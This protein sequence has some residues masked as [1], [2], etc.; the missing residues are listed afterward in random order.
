MKQGD[1]IECIESFEPLPFHVTKRLLPKKGDV[2]T[3]DGVGERRDG[4]TYILIKEESGVAINGER[5]CYSILKFREIQFP[6][7]LELEIKECLT[8]ELQE[9]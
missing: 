7:N 9:K 4:V 1:L 5:F 8:R 3:F 6:P 2:C